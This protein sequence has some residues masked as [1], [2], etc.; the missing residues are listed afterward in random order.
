MAIW[1]ILSC[2]RARSNA[3]QKMR[4]LNESPKALRELLSQRILVL[5]GAMGTM[6]QQC[7][8]TAEDFGGAAL[9]G[10]NENLVRTRPDVVLDIH[11]KYFEAGSD[12]VETNSFGGAPIVLAEYGLAADAHFLNRRSAALS[13]QAADEFSSSSKPPLVARSLVPTTQAITVT[14]GVTFN[15]LRETYY[16]QAKGL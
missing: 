13:R 4:N 3:F 16:A 8:L 11:R 14:G 1:A 12:I 6:L 7:N 10:C 15:E 5:D 2:K 9:E